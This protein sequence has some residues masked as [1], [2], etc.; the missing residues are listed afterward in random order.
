ML[1]NCQHNNLHVTLG[2]VDHVSEGLQSKPLH[3]HRNLHM[4]NEK[5]RLD[6]WD[7]S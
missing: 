1:L 6:G 3:W 2:G 7:T 5:A 4:N